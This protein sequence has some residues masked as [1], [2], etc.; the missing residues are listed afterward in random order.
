MAIGNMWMLGRLRNE[1]GADA[2]RRIGIAAAGL[3]E[4]GD[5]IILDVG[6]TTAAVAVAL[7]ERQELRIVVVITNS[8]TIALTLE[9]SIPR[10]TVIVT[11]GTLRPLQHSL[12]S[13][14]ATRVLEDLRADMAFIGCTGLDPVN[15][16]TNVNLPETELKRAMLTAAARTVIVADSSKFGRTD[17]GRIGPL[18]DVWTLVTEAIPADAERYSDLPSHILIAP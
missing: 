10:L 17:R 13:P 2:K 11:G 5:T 3:V 1:R 4:S 7:A 8:L 12:V 9:G 14:Y 18:D 16:V 6:T 15:G